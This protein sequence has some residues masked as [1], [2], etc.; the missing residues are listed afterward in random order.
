MKR[1]YD[2]VFI[3][4]VLNDPEMFPRISE[5]DQTSIKIVENDQFIWLEV[6]KEKGLYLLHPISA[7]TM[8]IH[9]HILKPYR[10][11]VA[12]QSGK[13]VLK[14][15]FENVHD[16]Y[17][18]LIAEIAVI[19]QDVYH[20]TKKQGF[21]DEGINRASLLKKGNFIDQYR[22]GITREEIWHQQQ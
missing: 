14:W 1:T 9:A 2:L 17:N 18:K 7:S 22:L 20:F 5:D 16:R 19:Y 3:N 12:K 11:E 13:D 6:E 21:K 4:R 8:Q 10:A 15:F